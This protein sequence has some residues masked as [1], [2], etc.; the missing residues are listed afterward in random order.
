MK[1]HWGNDCEHIVAH[2][3]TDVGGL[4]CVLIYFENFLKRI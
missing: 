1:I 2:T 3:E 4:G